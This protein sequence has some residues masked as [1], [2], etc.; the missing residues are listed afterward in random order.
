MGNTLNITQIPELF[1]R[2]NIRKIAYTP[3]FA[4]MGYAYYLEPD[5]LSGHTSVPLWALVALHHLIHRLSR[6]SI[7]PFYPGWHWLVSDEFNTREN[8][9]LSVFKVR[10]KAGGISLYPSTA[11]ASPC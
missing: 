3:L 4:L 11:R 10:S 6:L 2:N 8:N 5:S 7:Q 9:H 1:T